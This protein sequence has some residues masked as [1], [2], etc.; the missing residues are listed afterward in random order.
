[1]LRRRTRSVGAQR[2]IITDY[3]FEPGFYGPV[4]LY[5]LLG[6]PSFAKEFVILLKDGVMITSN[7]SSVTAFTISN[8]FHASATFLILMQGN[9]GFFGKGGAGGNGGRAID[10]NTGDKV[11]GNQGGGGGGGAGISS[12]GTKGGPAAFDGQDGGLLF[13]GMGGAGDYVDGSS[14]LA[15][16]NG[17]D[18]GRAI[19]TFR[20]LTLDIRD[21]LFGLGTIAGGGG[22]GYGGGG[23]PDIDLPP[24]SGGD[25]GMF[26]APGETPP[27]DAKSSSGAAGVAITASG[28]ASVTYLP[29]KASFN[30]FGSAP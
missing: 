9:A 5:T 30:L 26:G 22:G 18:G 23:F 17:A 29:N 7:S 16:T 10:N 20:D 21:P 11:P 13:A 27:S 14:N 25:G 1:M 4:D 28:G 2:G 3:I 12:G 19:L 8:S 15:P 24:T 6:S